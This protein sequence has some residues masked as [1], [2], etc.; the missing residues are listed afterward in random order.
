MTDLL[1][2]TDFDLLITNGDL[3]VGFSDLQHQQLLLLL[4]PGEL[5]ES[6]T[7][8]VGIR[9]DLLD[10][11]RAGALNAEIKRAFERDGMTLRTIRAGG[12]EIIKIDATYE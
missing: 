3:A 1:L 4:S 6:P 12:P 8:G 5:R 9:A 11:V 7:V 10:D 2:D